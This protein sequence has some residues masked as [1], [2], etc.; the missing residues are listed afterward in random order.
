MINILPS[1]GVGCVECS[2]SVLDLLLRE[3]LALECFVG[4]VAGC[5]GSPQ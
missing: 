5:I 4:E 3:I 2:G 1:Q